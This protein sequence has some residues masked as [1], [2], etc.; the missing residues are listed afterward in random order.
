MIVGTEKRGAC[1]GCAVP[2]VR[3]GRCFLC[4]LKRFLE[5]GNGIWFVLRVVLCVLG[6]QGP[7]MEDQSRPESVGRLAGS[8]PQ[9][10]PSISL[11][12]MALLP[13]RPSPHAIVC[14]DKIV[15]DQHRIVPVR[16]AADHLTVDL[17][18]SVPALVVRA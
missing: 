16:D 6:F 14:P 17:G 9:C 5:I 11:R 1:G 2:R 18:P 7:E 13:G 4:L 3:L 12:C 15:A 10:H 8:P